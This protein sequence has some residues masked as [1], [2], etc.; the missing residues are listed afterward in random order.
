M[1]ASV[2]MRGD[3]Q[4]ASNGT[5]C[6]LGAHGRPELEPKVRLVSCSWLHGLREAQEQ[7][8]ECRAPFNHCHIRD[9]LYTLDS[10]AYC[11]VLGY[12]WDV[13]V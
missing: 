4:T 12:S 8:R 13:A 10:K 1:S 6:N 11:V 2:R 3:V 7:N 9:K 5:D